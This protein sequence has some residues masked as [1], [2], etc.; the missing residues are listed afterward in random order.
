MASSSPP[1]T[2]TIEWSLTSL[3]SDT[4]YILYVE[5]K[6]DALK[7]QFLVLNDT[8]MVVF[9]PEEDVKSYRMDPR[10]YHWHCISDYDYFQFR[11]A[12]SKGLLRTGSLGFVMYR[13]VN[14]DL[15]PVSY[16]YDPAFEFRYPIVSYFAPVSDCDIIRWRWE[17]VENGLVGDF[18]VN[19]GPNDY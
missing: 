16:D 8:N 6:N 13:N 19:Y 12:F 18:E 15:F 9:L 10:R 5:D 11:N 2:P 3:R 1:S 4:T 7:K 14:G 17:E